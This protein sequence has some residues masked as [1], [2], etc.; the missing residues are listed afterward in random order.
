MVSARIP[1]VDESKSSTASASSSASS[2]VFPFPFFRVLRA[3]AG[4]GLIR[5]NCSRSRVSYSRPVISSSSTACL[6]LRRRVGPERRETLADGWTSEG[7]VHA[8]G[9]DRDDVNDLTKDF[10]GVLR[11]DDV[12]EEGWESEPEPESD[13]SCELPA[14][15]ES[16]SDVLGT[17]SVAGMASGPSSTKNS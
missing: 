12:D 11:L 8:G 7:S 17:E 15:S 16:D 1:V 4:S 5:S 14:S 13:S 3:Q 6:S 9:F 10:F 2:S